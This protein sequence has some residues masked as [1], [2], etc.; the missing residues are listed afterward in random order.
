[1]KNNIAKSSLIVA[2]IGII[3]KLMGTFR[4]ILINA[5]FG[6]TA[7]TDSYNTAVDIALI[8][9]IL[10]NSTISL[11]IIP[12]MSKVKEEKGLK[13]KN[14]YFNNINT[15]LYYKYSTYFF[16][17]NSSTIIGKNYSSRFYRS[18][19]NRINDKIS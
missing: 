18:L 8:G 17:N 4:T 10:V 12:V 7:F 19:A 9:M 1:M 15:N 2:I 5:A 3:S 11:A 14:R 16:N 13:A 6:Q